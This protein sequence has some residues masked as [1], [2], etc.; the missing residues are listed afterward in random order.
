MA[1]KKRPSAWA[2]LLQR[3]AIPHLPIGLVPPN[4][5]GTIACR[6]FSF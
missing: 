2:R 5:T 6:S 4:V 3:S 1:E